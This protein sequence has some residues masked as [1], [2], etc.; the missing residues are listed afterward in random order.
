[1]RQT[2]EELPGIET[3]L[4]DESYDSPAHGHSRAHARYMEY[5]GLATSFV[6]LN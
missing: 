3:M 2:G 1:V 4:P 5:G 6:S